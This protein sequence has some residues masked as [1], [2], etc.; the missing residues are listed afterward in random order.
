MA[1]H[2]AKLEVFY[3]GYLYNFSLMMGV[4]IIFYNFF[5]RIDAVIGSV[6]LITHVKDDGINK[7]PMLK[8]E[9]TRINKTPMLKVGIN[10]TPML[11]GN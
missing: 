9:L 4:F 11:K 1:H 2:Q 3:D 10:K 8:M 5:W 6:H 7:T